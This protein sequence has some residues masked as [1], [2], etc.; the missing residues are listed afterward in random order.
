MGYH[1][2]EEIPALRRLPE[3]VLIL[4]W[5]EDWSEESPNRLPT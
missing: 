1:T 2:L 4:D 5:T 3:N